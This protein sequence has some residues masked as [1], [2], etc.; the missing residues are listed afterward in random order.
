MQKW[1]FLN[2][3]K[4]AGRWETALLC[5]IEFLSREENLL[6]LKRE[7]GAMQATLKALSS[8]RKAAAKIDKTLLAQE[9]RADVNL[10]AMQS[11]A[12][13]YQVVTMPSCKCWTTFKSMSI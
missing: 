5:A 13:M 4:I 11:F 3:G 6:K 9:R 1:R 12:S 8:L 10:Q 7:E 2:F